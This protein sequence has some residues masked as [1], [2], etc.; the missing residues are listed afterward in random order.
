MSGITLVSRA[1]YA[2]RRRQREIL[3]KIRFS[4]AALAGAFFI[5]AV[6]AE[7]AT[8]TV[9]TTA[10]GGPDSLAQAISSANAAPGDD[11]ILFNLDGAG[12]HVIELTSALPVVSGNL[13]FNNGSG[14]SLGG[15]G[16]TNVESIT[17]QRSAAVGTPEFRILTISNGTTTGPTVIMEG[18]TLSN[19][20]TQG[21][22]PDDRG[23]AIYNDRGTL[24]ITA[25]TFSNNGAATGGAI[26]SEGFAGAAN[27][28]LTNCTLRDNVA[29]TEGGAIYNHVGVLRL[30]N[31]TVSNNSAPVG[32]GIVNSATG[33]G[34]STR[35]GN[36]LLQTG[37]SGAN[38][39]NISGTFISD[40]N[41]L[42]SDAANGD[43]G[44]GP[45]GFLSGSGDKRNTD[46]GLDPAGLQDNGGITKTVALLT[47]S[48]AIN[49]GNTAIAPTLDQRGYERSALSDIGAFEFGGTAPAPTPLPQ[50]VTRIRFTPPVVAE[51]QTDPVRFE[52]TVS[53]SSSVVFN[54]DNVDRT[55]FDDGTNGDLAPDD[56][57]WTIMFSPAEILSKNTPARVFRPFLGQVKPTGGS[58]VNVI[59]EV[60]TSEIGLRD[61][62]PNDAGGQETDYVANYAA[63]GSQLQIFNP[64][65]WTGRFYETH[66]DNFD[67]VNL[68]LV[69][70]RLDHR[71]H[72]VVRNSVQGIGLAELNETGEYGSDGF[73]QG[74]NTFPVS[75]LFDGGDAG[76]IHETGHQWMNYCAGTPFESGIPHWPKGDIAINVMGITLSG[77][78]NPPGPYNLT[79]TPNGSGG[80]S[81]G[82]GDP[83]NQTTFNTMELYLMGLIPPEEVATFFVLNDQKQNVNVGQVLQP[84]EVT[85]V[86]VNDVIAAHGPRVPASTQAQKDFRSA[87][88]VLSEQLLD[89]HAM[90]FYDYFARRAEE[91]QQLPFASGVVTGTCNPWFL[92][93]GSRSEMVSKI[94][95]GPVP[96]PTP[97]PTGLANISTRLRV[98][99]GDN[100]LI[101]GF[102]ITGTESKTVMLRAI[103]PSLS[104]P[105]KLENPH[106]ELRNE[107]GQLLESNDNWQ[108]S[109]RKQ[110]IINSTIAPT[111]DL[112]S[113]I[114][115]TLQANNASYTAIVRGVND[116]IGI[117]LVEAYDLNRAAKSKLANISTRGVV[118]TGDDVLIGGL[119][120]LGQ[121]QLKVIIRAIGPSL[122]VA[123]KLEDPILELRD[124]NGGLLMS[125]DNWRTGG[126][127]TEITSTGVPPTNDA[128][129][130]IVFMLP[131][132]GASYTAIVRGVGD[133]TGIAVV[134]VYALN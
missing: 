83:I 59:A 129:S 10:N 2:I 104:I 72:A 27:V 14:G 62:R 93:T 54:Y 3:I 97:I 78:G 80:Y 9:T 130:A 108:D 55:M 33:G 116:T 132:S 123:G 91:K 103:G 125:N 35:L 13:F 26:Y 118:R 37:P 8:F 6:S 73:L 75:S 57:I 77:S 28:G 61:V 39:H 112:E 133:T 126:Q 20:R 40:G 31:C 101:G 109:T 111:H 102:I 106:L 64:K 107:F 92:A 18:L 99:A 22:A 49:A 19:G 63:S 67:F 88:I 32:G 127:E 50:L 65:Q 85:T 11:I 79:F 94:P 71:T 23:A 25:C 17:V 34:A 113:A 110:D 51:T 29:T 52:A 12:P 47:G 89:A 48:P 21:V 42:S 120:V 122:S 86:T 124:G 69:G 60:W 38:L 121:D 41:N 74:V 117:G 82:V 131:A 56:G 43:G 24:F 30:L 84:S 66:V 105:G 53:G 45:G 134:E 5:G 81:V 36:T 15:A 95:G 58:P 68:V 70:G 4:F 90:A 16:T 119:I 1:A 87:T 44:T 7:A 115:A 96:S 46:P 128:E 98:E 76:F 100:V 114:I